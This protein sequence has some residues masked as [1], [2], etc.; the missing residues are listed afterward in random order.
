[1]IEDR[2]SIDRK[3]IA[4]KQKNGLLKT[5]IEE[6]EKLQ[7]LTRPAQVDYVDNNIEEIVTMHEASTGEPLEKMTP[8]RNIFAEIDDEEKEEIQNECF[9]SLPTTRS[10]QEKTKTRSIRRAANKT[11]T[12]QSLQLVVCKV[13]SK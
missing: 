6:K 5:I 9:M 4:N 2:R 8:R 1:M 3:S 12:S 7:I 10:R 11:I 13:C